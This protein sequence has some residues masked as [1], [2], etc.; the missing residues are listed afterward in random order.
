MIV[1]KMNR[2]SFLRGLGASVSLPSF[3]LSGSLNLNAQNNESI[4][5]RMGFTYIPNGVI[6]ENWKPKNGNK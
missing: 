6:M 5:L 4:P 2:R 3:C 1:N